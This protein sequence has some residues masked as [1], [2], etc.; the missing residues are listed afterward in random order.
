[1]PVP[2]LL[3]SEQCIFVRFSVKGF[4]SSTLFYRIPHPWNMQLTM[5]YLVFSRVFDPAVFLSLLQD[6]F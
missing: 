6:T 2:L 5:H 4:K 1:M 3:V